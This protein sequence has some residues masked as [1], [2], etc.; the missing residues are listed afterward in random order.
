MT[1]RT[2]Q[3]PV[4][5]ASRDAIYDVIDGE[6]D[7]QQAGE[8]NA[9]RSPNAPTLTHGDII[10]LI[11][12]YTHEAREAWIKGEAGNIACLPD[13]RKIA[14]LA[15]QGLELYGAP[16]REWHVPASAN[17]TGELHARDRGDRLAPTE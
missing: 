5:P 6:R 2:N 12:R 16:P 8:G 10:L 1:Q 7:Y 13:I 14:A 3:V 17:I 9:A 11:E 15:V 4:R